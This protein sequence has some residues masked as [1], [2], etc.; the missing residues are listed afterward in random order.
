MTETSNY[1]WKG[2]TYEISKPSLTD[3]LGKYYKNESLGKVMRLNVTATSNCSTHFWAP[4]EAVL[5]PQDTALEGSSRQRH[6]NN[7]QRA[8][9]ATPLL[10]AAGS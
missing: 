10:R 4:S 1:P 3:A 5:P 2:N 8:Q 6:P 9:V 7:L